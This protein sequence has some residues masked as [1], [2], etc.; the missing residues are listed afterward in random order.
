VDVMLEKETG[1]PK[2]HR[3]WI[4]ALM[5]S[6]FNQVNRILFSRQLGYRLEDNSLIPDIQYGSR[7]CRL[8]SSAVLNKVITFNI[9][10]S[11]KM[12]ATFI[13]NDTIS[14]YDRLVNPLLL[15]QLQHLGAPLPTTI[16]LSTTWGT[17]V[18][19]IKTLYG[20]SDESYENCTSTPLYGPSQGST[21]GPFLWL[22]VFCL[23]ANEMEVSSAMQLTTVDQNIHMTNLGEAFVDDSF[24]GVT[25]THQN[26]P[27]L[28]FQANLNRDK[29]SAMDNL[30]ETSQRWERLL[31]STG[32]ALNLNKSHWILVH[33]KWT[34][35]RV[36]LAPPDSDQLFL[37]AGAATANLISIPN[38][39][40]GDSYKTLGVVVSPLGDQKD[41]E[42]SL[43]SIAEEYAT[44]V[45]GSTLNREAAYWSYIL[46]FTPKVSYPLSTTSLTEQQCDHI[47]LPAVCTVLPKLHINRN[48]ARSIVF[49]PL[50]LGGFTL[51]NVFTAQCISQIRLLI[52]HLQWGDKTSVLLRIS[53]SYLQLII[54]SDKS[55]FQLQYPHYSKW[56]EHGWLTSVWKALHRAKVQ[57]KI[58]NEWVPVI[59]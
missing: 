25:S 41:I 20:V 36:H 15:L 33:W 58:A 35:G 54:G 3:L 12:T 47:Q 1:E 56:I 32:G 40:P 31:F 21:L 23:I 48:T 51:P 38:M 22:L 6:D 4:I 27:S 2:I 39:P 43:R 7:P 9:I 16:S 34:E 42:K 11:T 13:E 49:G 24:L 53:M 19:R 18:H 30:K 57:L 26:D 55:F 44:R 28:T 59:Q 17:T 46:C 29:A 52:G 14:C 45:R 5:E 10:R 50:E 37:S 8:C